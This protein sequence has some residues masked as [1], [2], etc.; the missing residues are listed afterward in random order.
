MSIKRIATSRRARYDY[1]IFETFE[2]GM[3][4][5]GSEVKSLRGGR[6]NL[7]DAYAI[8]KDGE[9]W[10]IGCHVSPYAFA[11]GGG[12]DPERTRKLLLH[13]H[14]IEK[15]RSQIAEKGRTLIPIR[16]Y[17]KDGKAKLELGLA[18]GKDRYDKRE[19]LKRKQADRE[20]QRAMR[21]RS[22]D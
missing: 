13:R 15:I 4:L 20:M 7:K 11:R 14:E 1:E 22:L 5:L 6:V 10:L 2:A 21:Y 19:T 18:R 9:A 3:V 17:F 8:I 12:H 16:M